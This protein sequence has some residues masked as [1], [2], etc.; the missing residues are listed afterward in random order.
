MNI[1]REMYAGM[2]FNLAIHVLAY[3][4]LEGEKIGKVSHRFPSVAVDM[5]LTVG[6]IRLLRFSHS[7]Q[8]IAK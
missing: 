3:I 5:V 8:M 6:A 7:F 2:D 4:M 1:D